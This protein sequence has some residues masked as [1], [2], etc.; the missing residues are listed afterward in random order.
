MLVVCPE[1]KR[2]YKLS[3]S[4]V[5][6]KVTIKLRCPKCGN[7]FRMK[8][9]KKLKKFSDDDTTQIEKEGKK[10]EKLS[11]PQEKS[12]YL[13]IISGPRSGYKYEIKKPNII[14]G[15]GSQTD[16]I[17]PDLEVSR[18]HC[19]LEINEDKVILRDLNST[20]GTYIDEEKIDFVE[21]EDRTE[22]KLGKSTLLFVESQKGKE[23]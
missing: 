20:N 6:D 23:F 19:S 21:L 13:Y 14:V 7:V 17:I 1:C 12:F 4:K 10:E 5:K 22:I 16:L 11:L 9:P 2:K 8:N 3:E 15:R 18:Q